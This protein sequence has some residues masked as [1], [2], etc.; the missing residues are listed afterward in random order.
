MTHQ[1][2]NRA[3]RTPAGALVLLAGLPFSAALLE[4][5]PTLQITSPA[6]G[7][8]VE[9]GQTLNI[10][11]AASGTF[12]MVA[13]L[14]SNPLGASQVLSAPPYQFSIKVPA[15]APLDTYYLTAFGTTGP[16]QEVDSTQIAINVVKSGAATLTSQPLILKLR[17][18]GDQAPL[19]ITA[20]Y[21]TGPPVDVSLSATTS[22][23]S[24]STSVATVSSV[25][26]VTATGPGSTYITVDNTLSVPVNVTQ[27][28]S[29]VPPVSV[30]YANQTQ[31]FTATL[32][33]PPPP[34]S[35]TWSQTLSG[36]GTLSNTGLYTAPSQVSAQQ[37]VTIT[38]TN[39]ANSAQS[40]SVSLLLYPPVSIGVVP[41]TATLGQSQTQQF[42][43]TVANVSTGNMAVA[44]STGPG[45]VGKVSNTG[46]YTA[47]ASITAM[48]TVSVIATSV[49][50]GVTTGFASVTLTPPQ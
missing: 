3:A 18:V 32:A 27:P 13:V 26:M 9:P 16:G 19:L 8:H 46:L 25:G 48:Q 29:V 2:A 42:T 20:Q 49:A 35:V 45:G 24:A 12:Q 37:A 21:A 14:G 33:L 43:A 10:T 4:A 6:N 28:V 23:V 31:Q 36:V 22:Y 50:E 1:I 40:A 17:F 15:W 11:V 38:A 47:P 30:L 39:A 5:Q 41:A 34:G 44:W 7:A